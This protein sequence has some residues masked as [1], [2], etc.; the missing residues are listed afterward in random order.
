MVSDMRAILEK[1]YLIASK[2]H[3]HA[4]RTCPVR[5][6]RDRRV[7]G[8]ITAFSPQRYHV[9]LGCAAHNA[10]NVLRPALERDLALGKVQGPVVNACD[11]RLRAAA[12]VVGDILGSGA[13]IVAAIVILTIGWNAIDPILSLL[14]ALGLRIILW[15]LK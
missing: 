13:T 9:A 12:H 8:R 3:F 7:V 15:V 4:P 5:H 1:N 11:T 6:G 10:R 2:K 14:L